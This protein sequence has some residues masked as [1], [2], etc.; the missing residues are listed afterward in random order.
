MSIQGSLLRTKGTYVR[1]IPPYPLDTTYY[2]LFNRSDVLFKYPMCKLEFDKYSICSA[3]TGYLD[4]PSRGLLIIFLLMYASTKG[5]GSLS[6]T[7]RRTGIPAIGRC[8]IV[9]HQSRQFDNDVLPALDAQVLVRVPSLQLP[10]DQ[11]GGALDSDL[12]PARV[13]P[14]LEYALLVVPPTELVF[15]S[16]RNIRWK[17][18]EMRHMFCLR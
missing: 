15:R 3:G 14:V 11:L 9:L 1:A 6:R 10:A 13:E 12:I 4:V 16:L 7:V 18:Q 17:G 5:G 8:S 2:A